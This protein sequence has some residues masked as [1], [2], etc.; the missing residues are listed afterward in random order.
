MFAAVKGVSAQFVNVSRWYLHIAALAGPRYVRI[1]L[2]FPN[3]FVS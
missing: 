1:N 2:N 3:S